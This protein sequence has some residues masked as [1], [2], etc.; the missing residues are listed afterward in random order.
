VINELL[1]LAGPPGVG[2]STL[3]A[4]LTAGWDREVHRTA[5]VPHSTLRHPVSGR[6]LGL[7]L[8]VPRPGFPGT[9]TLAMDISPRAL[10]F[11][12]TQ[13]VPF[14]LGEGSRL[15]TRPFLGSLVHA[16]VRLTFVSLT[17]DERLLTERWQ[18]RGAKQN[19]AWRKGATTRAERMYEWAEATDR[20]STLRLHMDR[21]ALPEAVAQV[22]ELFRPVALEVTR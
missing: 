7:E 10:Q 17:A 20:V 3:M 9:D 4:A 19:P 21:V 1:Y 6:V 14:A 2:K 13:L 12:S 11:L 16:G 18:D 22:Q 5:S 15:A 8:G